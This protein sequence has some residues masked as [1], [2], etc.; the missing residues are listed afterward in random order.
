MEQ[1]LGRLAVAVAQNV[2]KMRKDAGIR[3]GLIIPP[4]IPGSLGDAAML[5]AT[6]LYLQNTERIKTDLMYGGSWILDALMTKKM[7]A[8]RFFYGGSLLQKAALVSRLPEFS[9]VYFIG[10]DVIDGAY[11]PRSVCGRLAI[12]SEAA[13]LGKKATLLGASYNKHPEAATAAMLKSLPPEVTLC[14]RDPV[15]RQRMERQV[16]RAV[17][18]VA[19]LAFLLPSR[20]EDG[21]TIKAVDWIR[22]RKAGGDD[23]IAFNANYIHAEKHPGMVPALPVLLAMLLNAGL[24]IVLVPHDVRSRRPDQQLLAD[25]A[26]ALPAGLQQRLY[27]FPP[28]SPGAIKSML[29]HVDM[30]VT[31]RMHAAI[32]AMASGTP[33]YCFAYQDKFEGLYSFFEL[34][35][36]GLLSSPEALA[37]DPAAVG[38]NVLSR[39]RDCAQLRTAIEKHLPRVLQLS[40][41]NFS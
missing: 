21:E 35:D 12:L 2:A 16:G 22:A 10:A 4:A 30:I 17:R 6:A 18:Q 40:R 37:A 34:E 15:S 33:A 29:S 25:A 11:N 23:V 3:R 28:K 14:A 24:S 7:A 39:L 41:D 13:R 5:S 9:E 20:P 36:A 32:L 19:D 1:L 26:A 27:M 8:E 31:G 38:H